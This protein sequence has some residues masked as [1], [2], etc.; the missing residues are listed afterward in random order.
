MTLIFF[1]INFLILFV[2]ETK[3][4]RDRKALMEAAAAEDEIIVNNSGLSL[5]TI[6]ADALAPIELNEPDP[7][8][9]MQ[10]DQ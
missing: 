5:G 9:L 7:L 2:F 6:P 8:I 3:D 4:M 1:A 10:G